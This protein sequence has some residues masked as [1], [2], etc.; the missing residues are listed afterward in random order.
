MRHCKTTLP[1]SL[2]PATV[3]FPSAKIFPHSHYHTFIHSP[4]VHP[5]PSNHTPSIMVR[6]GACCLLDA[7]VWVGGWSPMNLSSPSC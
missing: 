5:D 2:N 7:C 4:T 6:T 3:H 1:D